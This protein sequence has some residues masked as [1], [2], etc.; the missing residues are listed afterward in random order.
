M[1]VV[2]DGL[3]S[4]AY[5]FGGS[6][7]VISHTAIGTGSTTITVGQT[8]L[9][10]ETDRN[11]LVQ[12]TDDISQL[13]TVQGNVVT[14]ISNYTSVEMSGTDLA[15]FGCF[16]KAAGGNMYNREVIGSVSFAGD[17]E[18]QISNSFLF[19]QP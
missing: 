16:N 12:P 17:V 14:A 11:Q 3:N 6:G 13:L 7:A 1:T 8:A 5:L 15:E 19:V 18:L 4:I 10:T 9:D 2:T